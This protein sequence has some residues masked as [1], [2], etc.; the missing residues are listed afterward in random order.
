[1]IKLED[2]TNG[3]KIN[4]PNLCHNLKEININKSNNILNDIG[5]MIVD[6][7]DFFD[8]EFNTKIT[9][10]SESD[11]EEVLLEWSM[12]FEPYFGLEN[13][14]RQKENNLTKKIIKSLMKMTLKCLS[15]ILIIW[16]RI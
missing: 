11:D 3:K 14:E 6:D 13:P 12:Y 4:P 1:M 8:Y 5:M 9:P 15:I 2:I 10:Q 16:N 7:H